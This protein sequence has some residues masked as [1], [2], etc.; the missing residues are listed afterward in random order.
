MLEVEAS[1]GST[2][3]SDDGGGAQTPMGM[4]VV[5]DAAL[6]V[7]KDIAK[8][9]T[10]TQHRAA[11]EPAYN[12]RNPATRTVL[13]FT[14]VGAKHSYVGLSE[15]NST[16]SQQEWVLRPSLSGKSFGLS[17]RYSTMNISVD[18]ADAE[19]PQE[20]EYTRDGALVDVATGK[21]LTVLDDHSI[22]GLSTAKYRH[23]L[24]QWALI[25]ISSPEG[26]GERYAIRHPSSGLFMDV[27]YGVNRNGT[28]V[29][30]W[31]RNGTGA[32]VWTLEEGG[33]ICNPMTE[34]C[35]NAGEYSWGPRS[36]GKI[37]I[38]EKYQ[39]GEY[40]SQTWE[41]TKDGMIIHSATGKA[42]T[43]SSDGTLCLKPF[44]HGDVKQQWML[45]PQSFA[46]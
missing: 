6:A 26:H 10:G 30:L 40:N 13:Q 14:V 32:Q 24:Q 16:V 20:F 7:T 21:A 45:V 28:R 17:V 12:I 8:Y 39:N 4:V 18:S 31:E 22:V 46:V 5:P 34:K 36:D 23:L 29:H 37:E 3:T 25:P 2:V 11:D 38:W 15:R 35:L 42:L 1:C 19:A 27:R 9:T 43:G 41:R 33:F 44:D